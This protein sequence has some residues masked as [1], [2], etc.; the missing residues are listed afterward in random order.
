MKF[1]WLKYTSCILCSAVGTNLCTVWQPVVKI[2][3]LEFV[4]TKAIRVNNRFVDFAIIADKCISYILMQ[5]CE[6]HHIFY[7]MQFPKLPY[8]IIFRS[9][10]S[11][12]FSIGIC[13]ASLLSLMFG[14]LQFSA[15][16]PHNSEESGPALFDT[17]HASVR[18]PLKLS[19]PK[20]LDRSIT[21]LV[22]LSA[23]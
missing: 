7:S 9:F 21:V 3:F 8:V 23:A 6:P 16:L 2:Y 4:Y 15:W 5:Y 22:L 12:S 14:A 19:V 1:D 20:I 11:A 18:L 17:T 13:S 10:Q